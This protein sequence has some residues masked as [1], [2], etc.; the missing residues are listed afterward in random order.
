MH[1]HIST[2][3]SFN[4][5]SYFSDKDIN[6]YAESSTIIYVVISIFPSSSLSFI[7]HDRFEN[8][9]LSFFFFLNLATNNTDI[10]M[11]IIKEE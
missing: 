8:F 6:R 11:K 7:Y 9:S 1:I 3:C 2:L 10:R 5:D 4:F